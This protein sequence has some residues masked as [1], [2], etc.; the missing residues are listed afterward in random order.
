MIIF[1]HLS[2]RRGTKLLINK[3][4]A[5]LLPGQKVA[6]IG[7]NGS[8]KSSLFA[9]LLGELTA[10]EGNVR[11]LDSLRLAHMAQEVA[12]TE[13][14]ARDYVVAG[15]KALDSVLRAIKTAEDTEDY[16]VLANLHQKLEALD[17]YSAHRRADHLLVGLGFTAEQCGASI[18][19][20]SGGWRIRLNLARALMTPSDLLLLDEPTN[21][22]DLDATLWLQSWLQNYDGTLMMI[23][24]DRD[25]IDATCDRIMR[26]EAEALIT[27][28]GG[29]SDYEIQ[30]AE[31]LN[32]QQ[33]RYEKQQ[34]RIS[35]INDFVRRF[36]AKATKARQAQSRLKELERMEQMAPAH[37]DSPFYFSFPKP[38]KT[39]DPLLVLDKASLGYAD[40]EILG[41]VSLR[42]C[43]GDRVGLIGRNGAGKS[44]LLKSLTGKLPLLA[45]DRTTGAH[46]R[47]GYF[48]QQQLEVLDLAASPLLHV[49]RLTPGRREQE[50]LDF[51][52]GFQFKGEAATSA[53]APFSG[54]EKAR[55]ALAL[56]V[57]QN[58]NLLILDEP[59]NHL[60]LEMR[61]ALEV[62][63]NGFEGALVLVSHDRHL[64]RNAVEDLILVEA[65]KTLP[66]DEDLATY[67]KWVLSA[68]TTKPGSSGTEKVGSRKEQRQDAAERRAKLKPLKK[69]IEKAERDFHATEQKLA[70]I[71]EALADPSL[72]ED[73]GKDALTK[74]L[75]DEGTLKGQLQ[76]LEAS[77]LE[78]QSS[79]EVLED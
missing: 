25:F 57:W 53:I 61:H 36:R 1:E 24:H 44:T 77:W 7:A 37:I 49:Q 2:L 62:A 28:K 41:N 65:G 56:V 29:Y 54:G 45:G 31:R 21:H 8:G 27:Y 20:F 78:H 14:A 19:T 26:I 12:I 6:L 32:Q 74:L 55:L 35:E 75:K 64:L 43:P 10:D 51:L 16:D 67:E 59:T 79:L 76:D 33:S 73:D 34:Q 63:I 40:N 23:S 38:G 15:D 42:F 70:S 4:E 52:G 18:A 60:D 71:K 66:Y 17:G 13:A 22:L 3:A 5:A 68:N 58:P 11:G 46:L 69:A 47:I 9:L 39:S 50:I 48:D 30:R 72:Y